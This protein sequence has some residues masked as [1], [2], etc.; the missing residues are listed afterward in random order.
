M[1]PQLAA[2]LKRDTPAGEV[3]HSKCE[4]FLADVPDDTFDLVMTSPPYENARRYG[5]VQFNLKGE[6]FVAWLTPICHELA[7]VC[8]GPVIVNIQ[9][10]TDDY[11]YSGVPMLLSADLIRGGLVARCPFIFYRNGIAGSGNL[12]YLRNDYEFCLV[13][14]KRAERFPWANPTACGH[15]PKWA[16]GGAFSNRL[17][18][19]KRVNEWGSTG[20]SSGPRRS[21][22]GRQYGT[23]PSHTYKTKKEIAAE[24]AAEAAEAEAAPAK[25]KRRATRGKKKGETIQAN[26]Y[27]PPKLANPGNVVKALYT[28]ED[29]AYLLHSYGVP[30]FGDVAHCLVGGGL[31]SDDPKDKDVYKHVA[32]MSIHLADFAIRTWCPPMGI[33]Y[34]PFAGSGTTMRAAVIAGRKGIGTDMD[35]VAVALAKRRLSRISPNLYRDEASNLA[36][37]DQGAEYGK[38]LVNAFTLRIMD[39]LY[40]VEREAH[41]A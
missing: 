24:A 30:G 13:F 41:R 16:P 1:N 18:N 25:P 34:D 8:R 9:G 21:H 33:V 40:D 4:D 31:M 19:G 14:S 29:V 37:F 6:A 15:P 12:D 20:H 36:R 35:D 26:E 23:R 28:A 10:K 5:K 2:L 17:P 22:G 7:R 32:P 27:T 39:A 11:A 38:K 3:L